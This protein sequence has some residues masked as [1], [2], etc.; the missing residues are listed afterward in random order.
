[1]KTFVLKNQNLVNALIFQ[2]GWWAILLLQAASETELLIATSILMI[3]AQLWV[4]QK[5]R[6]KILGVWLL[7]AFFGYWVDVAISKLQIIGFVENGPYPWLFLIWVLF[8]STLNH[9]LSYFR[10]HF[11]IGAIGGGVFGPL[12]Y[13]AASKWDII[14]YT[15]EVHLVIA[16]FLIWSVLF[17]LLLKIAHIGESKCK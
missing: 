17:V 6:F 15:S 2:A 10:Q 5:N 8:V 4:L 16:H 7:I 9:S 14:T 3:G 13:F 12:S 11:W 1:M